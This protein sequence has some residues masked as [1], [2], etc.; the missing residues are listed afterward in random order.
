[1]NRKQK[2]YVVWKGH[3][4]G[5]YDDWLECKAQV[6]GYNNSKYRAYPNREEAIA[7]YEAG[8]HAASKSSRTEEKGGEHKPIW[9]SLSVDAACSGNPGDMEYRGVFTWSKELVFHVGPLPGGTNNIGEF[10]ALV[11]G[12]ALCKQK[13]WDLPIYT[14]SRT[15][16]AWVREKKCKTLLLPTKQNAKIFD[17]IKRAENWLQH[18]T[19]TTPIYKW[20]TGSWSE[21]PADFGRK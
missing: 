10:L 14:D 11:H 16:M 15:A 19:Y 18:N 5:V 7:A 4:P 8:Y 1:M 6:E 13:G 20:D 2:C 9:R 21:I 3:N 17:L 12:L